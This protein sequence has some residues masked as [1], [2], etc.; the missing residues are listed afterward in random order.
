MASV[1]VYSQDKIH[2]LTD[3]AVVGAT[4]TDGNLILQLQDGGTIDVGDVL[5]SLA[6][7]SVTVKGVIELATDTEVITGTDAVRAVTPL[8][9]AGLTSTDTRKGLVELATTAE[10]TTGTDTARAVTPAGLKTVADTK[11]P[12]DSDLTAIAALTPSNDDVVQRK[13]GAWT[14]R[15]LS[16]L[17]TDLAGPLSSTGEFPDILLWGGSSYADADTTDIYVGPTDPGSV[18]NGS[19]WFDTTGT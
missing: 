9:L 4:I 12:L 7:A 14:N 16:Q 18:A 2:E 19:I 11:Q 1:T 8:G 10:A 5:T 15:T 17:A 6:D 13:S 3:G